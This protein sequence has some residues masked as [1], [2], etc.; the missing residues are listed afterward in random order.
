M[1]TLSR[2][3]LCFVCFAVIAGLLLAPV[4]EAQQPTAVPA[5][6]SPS[7][8][9]SS[10]NTSGGTT[11]PPRTA[12]PSTAE[13]VLKGVGILAGIGAAVGLITYAGK[14]CIGGTTPWTLKGATLATT[15]GVVG[16]LLG[17]TTA[18]IGSYL[19][20]MGTGKG[21]KTFVFAAAAIGAAIGG[22]VGA[23]LGGK[24]GDEWA[25]SSGSSSSPSTV[26]GASGAI[27]GIGGN[28]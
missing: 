4:V 14:H 8:Q 28:P 24:W 13:T 16:A 9:P 2:P 17:G 12:P 10:S 6:T 7:T 22:F 27:N 5:P 18:F 15:G 11:P 3:F 25:A 21:S 1:T 26:G 20:A 19:F 23:L